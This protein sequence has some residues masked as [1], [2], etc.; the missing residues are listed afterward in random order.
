MP[1]PSDVDKQK[2]ASSPS[3]RTSRA[4]RHLLAWHG[5]NGRHALPWRL[6]S[7]PYSVLVSEFMLQQMTVATVTPRFAAWM[8][9]F[10][11]IAALAAASERDVLSAWEGLGYYSRARRLYAAARAIIDRHGG[12][13]PRSEEELLSLPGIGAYTA[14]AVRAFAFDERAVVLDTNIIR[15]LARWGDLTTPVDT[16]AGKKTL[17]S[18]AGD[19]FPKGGCRAVASALMDLGATLCTAGKPACD[20]CPLRITCLADRPEQ[21]PLKSPRRV[22]TKVS[23]SRAWH[24]RDGKLY[25]QLSEGP[26]WKG[27]WILPELDGAVVGRPLVEHTY[28]ITRY[29]VTMKVWATKGRTPKGLHGF[30]PEEI[31]SLPIPSPHRRA[32]EAALRAVAKG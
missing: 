2:S 26:R 10:P 20:A 7:D 11:D 25:L 9:R 8:T 1:Y 28:P 19:F 13:I 31:E 22:A 12:C 3:H 18:L 23:E 5:K 15:V 16:A 4:R 6:D 30:T 29:R 17:Q 24:L 27:L 14:A 21:L 32:I